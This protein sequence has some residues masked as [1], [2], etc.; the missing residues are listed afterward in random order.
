MIANVRSVFF[1]FSTWLSNLLTR[2]QVIV[3]T[4]IAITG[5]M[6][7]VLIYDWTQK[8]QKKHD[9]YQSILK[10]QIDSDVKLLE[11]I[12]E[13][14]S[15]D[16]RLSKESKKLKDQFIAMYYGKTLFFDGC[17][18]KSTN[19]VEHLRDMKKTI[20]EYYGEQEAWGRSLNDIKQKAINLSTAL[21]K[22]YNNEEENECK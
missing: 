4:L 19:R 14:I 16:D 1:S 3:T 9:F 13:L 7:N 17:F 8:Q 18:F 6:L 10:E 11:I 12:G 15:Q 21:S 22:S 20:E 2:H 5:L